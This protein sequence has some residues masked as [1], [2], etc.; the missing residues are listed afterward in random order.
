[1]GVLLNAK[2][3]RLLRPSAIRGK[4]RNFDLNELI[5]M[6]LAAAI[7]LQAIDNS[8]QADGSETPTFQSSPSRDECRWEDLKVAV[9]ANHP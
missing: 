4:K 9:P 7:R 5:N 3:E 1:M 8:D 6:Q 2:T